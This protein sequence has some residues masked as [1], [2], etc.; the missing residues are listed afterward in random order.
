MYIREKGQLVPVDLGKDGF[1]LYYIPE[2]GQIMV[3]PTRFRSGQVYLW[4]RVDDK[5]IINFIRSEFDFREF[6]MI[7]AE[8][9]NLKRGPFLRKSSGI[10]VE[11][12]PTEE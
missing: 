7:L 12:S 8:M 11:L 9:F 6:A 4:D 10:M 1:K 5:Q 3:L 2:H